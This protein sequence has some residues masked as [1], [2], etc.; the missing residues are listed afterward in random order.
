MVDHVASLVFSTTRDDGVVAE[1]VAHRSGERR[2]TIEDE[3]IPSDASRPRSPSPAIRPRTTVA[4]S[5]EPST[6]PRGT[7]VP[8]A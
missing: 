4:F 5:V 7:L 8:S 2:A 1:H 6:T 3:Q